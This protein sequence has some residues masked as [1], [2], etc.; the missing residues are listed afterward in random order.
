MVLV[1]ATVPINF[2]IWGEGGKLIKSI[3]QKNVPSSELA[4]CGFK[5]SALG[6]DDSLF[7]FY[8]SN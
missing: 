1:F 3:I 8:S 2:E 6:N 4:D 5:D 7:L